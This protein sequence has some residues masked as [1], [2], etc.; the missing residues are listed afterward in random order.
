MGESYLLLDC[1]EKEMNGEHAAMKRSA[2]QQQ[3]LTQLREF[4]R[5]AGRPARDAV[6]PVFQKL[7][8]DERTLDSFNETVENFIKRIE[9]RAPEKK[10]EMDA[11]REAE[12]GENPLGPGGLDPMA[13]L[14]T[15]PGEMQEAFRTQDLQRL[16]RAIESLPEEEAKYHLR[17]CEDS[18]L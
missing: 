3:L 8:D 13:V 5:A 7:L 16:Q 12:E 11:E 17:R 10:K 1:L 6:H 15:L 4:S 2:R 18:G 9:K 14:R